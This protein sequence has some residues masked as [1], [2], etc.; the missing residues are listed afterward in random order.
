MLAKSST[1]WTPHLQRSCDCNSWMQNSELSITILLCALQLRI[2][3]HLSGDSRL[4]QLL[5][6]A[7]P[8][9]DVFCAIA[10]AWLRNNAC[11]LHAAGSLNAWRQL[12][13]QHAARPAASGQAQ[14]STT[15]KSL[16]TIPARVDDLF[17]PPTAG[18]PEAISKD[19][20]QRAKGVVY[21]VI[22]GRGAAGLGQQLRI[23]QHAAQQLISSFLQTFPQVCTFFHVL[24]HRA[25]PQERR[26]S[27]HGRSSSS[28]SWNFTN[29]QF[30][31]CR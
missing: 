8:A 10:A 4:R 2:L 20:R 11:E 25:S 1:E 29:Y 19:E 26:G 24:V 18:A 23:P 31:H 30:N 15:S 13:R 5:C 12:R 3:A 16:S 17:L 14:S 22:Y 9:G 7:G 21:S 28:D 27:H 6:T